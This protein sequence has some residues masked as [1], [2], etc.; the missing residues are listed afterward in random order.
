MTPLHLI[1][2]GE[3]LSGW[4]EPGGSPDPGLSET[5]RAQAMAAAGTLSQLPHDER[6]TC[7]ITS[8][9]LRCRETAQPFEGLLGQAARVELS[10]AEIPTPDGIVGE[11]RAPWLRAAMSGD[12]SAMA[13]I[14]GEAWRARVVDAL[15]QAKDAAVFTHFVAINA[16]VSAALGSPAVLAFRPAP[17][18]ITT[19]RVEGSRLE[20]VRLGREIFIE[21]RVL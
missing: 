20:L 7:A 16:A 8:P 1:R 13:G 5:G 6:P 11:G 4:G 19:L 14:D 10:V 12:W 9:L 17:G 2:H 3:P 21:G 15:L 18:S